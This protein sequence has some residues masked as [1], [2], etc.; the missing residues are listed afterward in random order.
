MKQQ[1]EPLVERPLDAVIQQYGQ[2]HITARDLA[3]NTI[4]LGSPGSGKTSGVLSSLITGAMTASPV[5]GG[6]FNTAKQDDLPSILKPITYANRLS[7]SIIINALGEFRLN[8]LEYARKQTP[9]G[10]NEAITVLEM[11][12]TF[13]E[14]VNKSATV[15][16]DPFWQTHVDKF[17]LAAITLLIYAKVSLSVKKM[18]QILHSMPKNTDDISDD[19]FISHSQFMYYLNLAMEN[20]ESEDNEEFDQCV[21]YFLDEMTQVDQRTSS[22]IVASIHATLFPASIGLMAKLLDDVESNFSMDMTFD[23]KIIIIDLPSSVYH[24][25]GNLVTSM[26]MYLWQ[27]DVMKRDLSK[28]NRAVFCFTDEA[29]LTINKQTVAFSSVCRSQQAMCIYASQSLAAIKVRLG[30]QS[31]HLLDQFINNCGNIYMLSSTNPETLKLFSNLVGKDYEMRMGF[32]TGMGAGK[33]SANASEDYR[34]ILPEKEFRLLA[35]GGP[36]NNYVVESIFVSSGRI[37]N[38]DQTYLRVAFDQ[39][40]LER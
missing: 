34:Y 14:M 12:R 21:S 36:R 1:L 31:D 26:L 11:F 6:L 28:N 18:I 17:C 15:S 19:N 2:E 9:E 5:M 27:K 4:I 33:H 3:N 32:N 38:E 39:K 10:S 20:P 24:E 22:N 25:Q 16:K 7:D 13:S 40:M 30:P 37:F 23:G 8:W 29:Q 35:T